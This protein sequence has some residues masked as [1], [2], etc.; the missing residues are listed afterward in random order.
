MTASFNLQDHGTTAAEIYR[1]LPVGALY[2][3][4]IR[5]EKDARIVDNGALAA[6]SGVKTGRSPKDK[7]LVKHP[8]SEAEVWW[9]PVNIPIEP[10]TFAINRERARDY[11]NS[12]DQLYCVDGVVG[13]GLGTLASVVVRKKVG[14]LNGTSFSWRA[15][16]P[17]REKDP[18]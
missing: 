3:H 17:Q 14:A 12:R 16:G 6:Y 11:L 13:K 8:N 18:H 1:N 4:A 7:R 10:L 9:G 15:L 2:E 5:Y